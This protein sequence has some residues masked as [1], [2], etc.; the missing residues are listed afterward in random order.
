MTT[1]TIGATYTS[2]SWSDYDGEY[3]EADSYGQTT[4]TITSLDNDDGTFT[5]VD[6][7]PT[8]DGVDWA[9]A[10]FPESDP[11]YY[12]FSFRTY[13]F[14]WSGGTTYLFVAAES[15]YY[16]DYFDLSSYS[17]DAYV[18]L[19]LGGAELPDF[20]HIAEEDQYEAFNEFLATGTMS[21]PTTGFTDGTTFNLAD[22]DIVAVDEDDWIAGTSEIDTSFAG[23]GDDYFY[24]YYNKKGDTLDGGAGIDTVEYR[25]EKGLDYVIVDLEDFTAN[26]GAAQRDR[27]YN[28][29]NVITWRGDDHVAGSEADNVIETKAGDDTLIGRGG[30]DMLFG[31]Q[32][33]DLLIGGAGADLLD[34]GNS[35]DMVLYSSSTHG[36][37]IDMLPG[38]QGSGDALGDTFVDIEI[39][40]ATDYVDILRGDHS[41]N[42]LHGMRGDD[43]LRG[44]GGDDEL[45]GQGGD[46]LLNGD[47]GDDYMFGGKGADTF[48]FTAGHDVIEDLEQGIDTLQISNRFAS[49]AT[50]SQDDLRD[51]AQLIDGTLTLVFSDAHSLTLLGHTDIDTVLADITG[52]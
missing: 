22:L 48:Q 44:R 14:T 36:L 46:D 16:L 31:G 12:D 50:L 49:G 2:Y 1:Y 20:S 27:L 11:F 21:T 34:G 23:D 30:D 7:I 9:E 10:F 3:S 40:E 8:M 26:G 24:E 28:I 37:A 33:K 35:R 25:P 43:T 17:T 32:G 5:M 38:G 39:V 19:T 29:E 4:A 42:R 52:F 47:A 13:E 15:Y 51:A 41:D 6:G 18:Y 45:F